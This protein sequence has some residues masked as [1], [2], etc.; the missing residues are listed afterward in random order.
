MNIYQI[1]SQTSTV[2]FE[3]K[4]E[5][6]QTFVEQAVTQNINLDH[7]D[8]RFRNMTGFTLDGA[9]MHHADF[10]GCN[11]DGANLSESDLSYADFTDCTLYNACLAHSNLR[12]GNFMR[13]FFG[14]TDITGGDLSDASF[15]S[16]S[17]FSLNFATAGSTQG[18]HFRSADGRVSQMTDT[19]IIIHG[20]DPQPLIFIDKDMYL[21]HRSLRKN[22]A[23]EILKHIAND[24]V[25]RKEANNENRNIENFLD[26]LST[27]D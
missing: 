25:A 17:C 24:C 14:A 12:A 5:S 18:A 7:A 21:G 10:T 11:L 16:L 8:F 27:T 6:Y 15:S 13:A 22:R 20:L 23:A 2:L 19:P 26:I 4:A 9:Q 3:D 1:I